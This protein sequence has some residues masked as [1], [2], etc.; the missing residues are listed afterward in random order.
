MPQRQ[1][2]R[3]GRSRRIGWFLEPALLLLLHRGSSHGYTL[4]EKLEQLGLE[5]LHPRVVYRALR[6]MEENE[7][8]TSTWDAEQTQGPPRRIYHLATLG[9]DMLRLCIQDLQQTREQIDEL[10]DAY[11]KHMDEGTGEHH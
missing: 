1:R 10:V 4:T 6:E 2:C 3:W 5:S 8:V 11:G 7:W 9:N